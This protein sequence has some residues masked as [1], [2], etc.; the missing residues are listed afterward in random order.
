MIKKIKDVLFE[1]N[2]YYSGKVVQ[3]KTETYDLLAFV[4]FNEEGYWR[5]FIRYKGYYATHHKNV[6]QEWARL[7]GACRELVNQLNSSSKSK[8]I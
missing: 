2:K 8:N 4:Y 1:A 5:Y 3:Y 7:E 6:D